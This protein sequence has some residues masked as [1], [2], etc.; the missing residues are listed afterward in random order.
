MFPHRS[1]KSAILTHLSLTSCTPPTVCLPHI[2]SL[3][4]Q[5]HAFL[6]HTF[7]SPL[8]KLS[9]LRINSQHHTSV[10]NTFKLS[11]VNNTSIK[12]TT[13][14]LI[15]LQPSLPFFPLSLH[16]CFPKPTSSFIF[17]HEHYTFSTSSLLRGPLHAA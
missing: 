15:C 5:F 12:D 7:H 4:P 9:Y 3:Y 13:S 17:L 2:S 11:K 6:C 1:L 10:L 14:P 8:S 16:L